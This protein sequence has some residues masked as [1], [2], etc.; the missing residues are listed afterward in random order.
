MLS[1]GVDRRVRNLYIEVAVA[2]VV[3]AEILRP[4]VQEVLVNRPL[5]IYGYKLLQGAPADLCS[6]HPD[7][8]EGSLVSKKGIVQPVGGRHVLFRGQTYGCCQPFALVVMLAQA[9]ERAADRVAVYL[10]IALK[11]RLFAKLS[12]GQPAVAG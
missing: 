8:D 2:L 11:L 1:V 7:L 9:G 10:C 5:L 12:F 4:F 3:V 6:L